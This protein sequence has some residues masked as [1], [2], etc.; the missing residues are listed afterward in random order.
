MSLL[1]DFF[2]AHP[3]AI[4]ALNDNLSC[5]QFSHVQAKRVDPIKIATLDEILT[6]EPDHVPDPI[7]QAYDGDISI[8][9]IRQALADKLA[10]LSDEEVPQVALA[11]AATEEWQLD[12]GTTD[13]LADWLVQAKTLA[14]QAQAT[15]LRMYVRISV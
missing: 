15:S 3:D 2:I 7:R 5:E 10:E 9:A 12:G 14:K 6:Q 13:D 8:V 1:T 4:W 11:W